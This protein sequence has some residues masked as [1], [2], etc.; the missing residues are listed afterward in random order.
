MYDYGNPTDNQNKYGQLTPP[1]I[2][3]QDWIPAPI[4]I[5]CAEDD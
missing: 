1:E 3:V 2:H 5:W 4:L